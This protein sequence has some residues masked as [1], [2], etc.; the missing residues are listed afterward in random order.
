MKMNP[1]Q[2]K[3][4]LLPKQM[5]KIKKM[6]KIRMVIKIKIWAMVKGELSKMKIGI[7]KK[8]QDHHHLLTQEL[9]K[10]FNVTIRS[11]IFLVT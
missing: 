5:I 10:P 9:D 7:I 2:M 6:N 4:L 3:L 8:S 11:T 1:L